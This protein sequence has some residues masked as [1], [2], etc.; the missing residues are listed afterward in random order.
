LYSAEV[1]EE[2]GRHLTYRRMNIFHTEY[3]S[4]LRLNI[5]KVR[6]YVESGLIVQK[7]V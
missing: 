6:K 5:C 1:L 3:A 2:P 7:C 4:K